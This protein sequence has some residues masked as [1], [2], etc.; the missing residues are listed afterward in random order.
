M[1][2]EIQ[3]AVEVT[4]AT[5]IARATDDQKADVAEWFNCIEDLMPDHM[6]YRNRPDGQ[7]RKLIAVSAVRRS[8]GQVYMLVYPADDDGKPRM[9]GEDLKTRWVQV[10]RET[11]PPDFVW[12]MA[13]AVPSG[14]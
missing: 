8:A 11:P 14:S 1:Q 12:G 5:F 2:A 7:G 10:P 13:V 4:A 6:Y 3:S 9:S